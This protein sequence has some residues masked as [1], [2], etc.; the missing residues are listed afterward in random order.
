MEKEPDFEKLMNAAKQANIH[1]RIMHFPLVKLCFS[2][3]V[4]NLPMYLFESVFKQYETIIGE[5]GAQLS[6][7]ERQRISIGK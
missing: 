1:N 6:G 3:F 5:K 4:F 7:G 2:I